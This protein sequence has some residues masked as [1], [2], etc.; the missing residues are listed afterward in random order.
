MA[1][2]RTIKPEFFTSEDIAFLTPLARLF[3]IGLWCEA[4]REGRLSWKP[5]TLKFRY[6]P[7]DNIDIDLIGQELIDQRLI[8]TYEVDGRNYAQ[9]TSF[10]KHQVIN[11]RESK[12]SIPAGP[13]LITSRAPSKIPPDTRLQVMKRDKEKCVRCDSGADLTIDHIIPQSCGGSHDIDNLRILCR[14][15][16]AGRPVCGVELDK[17][18]KRDGFIFTRGDKVPTRESGVKAEGKGRKEGKG[19]EGNTRNASTSSEVIV[20][21]DHPIFSSSGKGEGYSAMNDEWK[22]SSAAVEILEKQHGINKGFADHCL[23]EFILYWKNRGETRPSWDNSF[24]QNVVRA[25][26]DKKT[27]DKHAA[28]ANGNHAAPIRKLM[29]IPG[30]TA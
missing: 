9:I 30:R 3:F 2:I 25:W 20:N 6:L 22:P 1:R 11:N 7:A 4:D 24:I 5:K 15:C 28:A 14:S 12:S 16:N 26:G 23:P 27:R 8:E 10:S 13:S 21:L 17:D 29:P 19:R 18:L